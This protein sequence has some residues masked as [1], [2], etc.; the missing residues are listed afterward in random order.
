[1]AGSTGGASRVFVPA[2]RP[3]CG[4]FVIELS[5]LAPLPYNSALLDSR[6]LHGTHAWRPS[7]TSTPPPITRPQLAG[8]GTVASPARHRTRVLHAVSSKTR[9]T[10]NERQALQA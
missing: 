4:R 6:V 5:L 10:R 7:P 1:A 3:E 9:S 8:R 2:F